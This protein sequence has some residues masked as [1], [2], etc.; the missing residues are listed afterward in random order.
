MT[1]KITT[2][3]TRFQFTLDQCEDMDEARRLAE[4]IMAYKI[5]QGEFGCN[6]VF[7]SIRAMQDYLDKICQRNQ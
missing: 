3:N 7:L 6:M 4:Q 5:G 1:T 2:T